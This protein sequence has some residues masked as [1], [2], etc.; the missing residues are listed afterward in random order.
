MDIK[1]HDGTEYTEMEMNLDLHFISVAQ[2][3][4]LG[5]DE[6]AFVKPVVTDGGPAFSIH[7][8]DGTQMGIATNA[9]L[10]AAAIIQH[11]MVPSLVH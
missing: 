8:A 5:M 3:A 1:T 9:L 4:D 7:A 10:A 2:L 11:D 6:I